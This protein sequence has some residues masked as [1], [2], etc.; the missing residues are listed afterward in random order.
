M[1]VEVAG[2]DD[3]EGLVTGP[4]VAVV[5]ADGVAGRRL[6]DPA[7]PL[8]DGALGVAGPLSSKG[9]EVGAE[10][11]NLVGGGLGRGGGGEDAPEDERGARFEAWSLA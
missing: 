3:E 6:G 1:R 8:R 7:G 11:R 9:G 5:L 10:P 4:G 2:V